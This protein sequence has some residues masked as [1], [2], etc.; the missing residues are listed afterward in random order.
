MFFPPLSPPFFNN[1]WDRYLTFPSD[2]FSP[3]FFNL[4]PLI[5]KALKSLIFIPEDDDQFMPEVQKSVGNKQ[6]TL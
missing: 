4:F 6:K 5:G 2:T 1:K 3:F